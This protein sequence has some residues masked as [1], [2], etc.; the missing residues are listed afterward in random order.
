MT[1]GLQINIRYML[2]KSNATSNLFDWIVISIIMFYVFVIPIITYISL[3]IELLSRIRVQLLLLHSFMRKVIVLLSIYYT[4]NFFYVNFFDST[5]SLSQLLFDYVSFHLYKVLVIL[6]S[7]SLLSLIFYLIWNKVYKKNIITLF[8]FPLILCALS[9]IFSFF[10]FDKRILSSLILA[11]HNSILVIF[12]ILVS[13]ENFYKFLNIALKIFFYFPLF[14]VIGKCYYFYGNVEDFEL[15]MIT[16][17]FCL[18]FFLYGRRIL[19]KYK[20]KNKDTEYDVF[21]LII[22][23]FLYCIISLVFYFSSFGIYDF[24]LSFFIY[25]IYCLSIVYITINDNTIENFIL[26]NKLFRFFVILALFILAGIPA[27]TQYSFSEIKVIIITLTT[28]IFA[29]LITSLIV[30]RK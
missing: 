25:I 23:F 29:S 8:Y 27:I 22:T 20:K 24:I 2:E 19:Y 14:L 15:L 28:N 1:S 9:H 3:K 26:N 10:I 5:I 18:S 4:T 16:L 13:S 12:F 11:T 21:L 7:C 30:S 6:L 17:P